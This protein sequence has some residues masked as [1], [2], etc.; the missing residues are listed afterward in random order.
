MEM[1]KN[2]SGK[3]EFEGSVAEKNITLFNN[4]ASKFNYYKTHNKK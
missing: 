3:I 1:T 4:K 2:K